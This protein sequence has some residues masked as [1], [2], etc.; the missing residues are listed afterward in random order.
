MENKG[1]EHDWSNGKSRIVTMG[2]K[3]E[4]RKLRERNKNVVGG[5]EL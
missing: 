4:S 1:R 3:E 5:R 2:W